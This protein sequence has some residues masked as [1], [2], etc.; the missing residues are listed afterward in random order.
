MLVPV[1]PAG[2]PV[3][4][5]AD[6]ASYM[7][8]GASA[9]LT[10]SSSP[11]GAEAILDFDYPLECSQ[12]GQAGGTDCGIYDTG[13]FSFN[14]GAQGYAGRYTEVV[15]AA[16]RTPGGK[17]LRQWVGDGQNVG[18]AAVRYDFDATSPEIWIRYYI[19]YQSG[20][21]WSG[22]NPGYEKN[23]YLNTAGALDVL[24]QAVG[25]NWQVT[26]QGG[27][28]D[29]RSAT[30]TTSWQD[31]F[32]TTSDGNFHAVEFHLKMDTDSTDGIVQLWLD[33]TLVIDDSDVDFSGGSASIRSGFTWFEFMANQNA[34]A[35]SGGI[36]DPAYVDVDDMV[37]YTTIPPN[38]DGAGNAWIGL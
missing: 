11:L 4:M 6:P 8:T 30:P 21:A 3:V 35:N 25:S 33:G 28:G 37:I 23:L 20:F 24:P 26:M 1:A 14:W 7:F 2:E 15:S 22:G 36:G 5:L 34:P 31:V 27:A 29:T 13:G 9:A 10:Q 32:G 17:G 19:R 16:S 38:T 18:T 12:R